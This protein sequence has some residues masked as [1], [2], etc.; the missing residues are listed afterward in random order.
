M[1]SSYNPGGGGGSA[2]LLSWTYMAGGSTTPS[3]HTFTYDGSG[4]LYF[5]T[6]PIGSAAQS[7]INFSQIASGTQFSLSDSSGNPIVFLSSAITGNAD[8]IT[9]NMGAVISLSAGVY[10]LSAF[11]PQ[12]PNL[13]SV[14]TQSSITPCAD[15]TVTPVTSIT[16]ANGVITAIS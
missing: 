2:Q 3:A 9:I 8:V 14:L 16:T 13:F 6:T 7:A 10:F 5:S 4:I 12:V 1:P 15:G 11:P